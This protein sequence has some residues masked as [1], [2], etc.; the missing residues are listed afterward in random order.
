MENCSKKK[1]LTEYQPLKSRTCIYCGMLCP[2]AWEISSYRNF[3]ECFAFENPL[4]LHRH[5]RDTFGAS[6]N[7]DS[8]ERT[9]LWQVRIKAYHMFWQD[10]SI[11]LHTTN[12]CLSI[13]YSLSVPFAKCRFGQAEIFYPFPSF[14]HYKLE[15]VERFPELSL[16]YRLFSPLD[17]EMICIFPYFCPY[18]ESVREIRE[19]F[20]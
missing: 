17:S 3:C 13:N 6:L 9:R 10:A 19:I 1:R 2:F 15:F 5:N 7:E 12:T 18:A 14:P 20:V 8:P 4:S 11:F 16:F